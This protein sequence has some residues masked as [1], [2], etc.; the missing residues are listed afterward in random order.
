MFKKI[1]SVVTLILVAFIAYNAFS[2]EVVIDGQTVKIECAETTFVK[3]LNPDRQLL[4][5]KTQKVLTSTYISEFPDAEAVNVDFNGN[6]VVYGVD[7]TTLPNLY[8]TDVVEPNCTNSNVSYSISP[9]AT[10]EQKVGNTWT[11]VFTAASGANVYT[12][13]YTFTSDGLGA[14][15]VYEYRIVAQDYTTEDP[16][17]MTHITYF[18]HFIGAATRNKTISI[19][20]KEDDV[21][22]MALYHEILSTDGNLS[23]QLKN[24]NVDQIKM[25][26]TKFY[27]DDT[28]LE[29]NYYNISQGDYAIL[30]NLP[31]GYTAKVKIRGGSTEGYLTENPN[32]RGKRLRLPFAN[33]Q[34]IKLE[35]TLERT[36]ITTHWGIQQ[37]R[38]SYKSVRENKI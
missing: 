15:Y 22:T 30:V 29:S 5:V 2:A 6:N 25:Q 38:T 7:Y 26:Q 28:S 20:F 9:C 1:L 8:I 21:E 18:T 16:A 36:D 34:N 17:K 19:E 31:D 23:I 37:R 27:V 32:V 11:K 4:S 14:G 24:M 33:S 12:T 35:V 13:N 10:L 3:S